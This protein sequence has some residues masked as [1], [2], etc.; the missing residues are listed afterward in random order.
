M[1]RLFPM[2]IVLALVG[3]SP[4]PPSLEEIA[5]ARFQGLPVRDAA[6]SVALRDGVWR[7]EPFAEG[8][9]ARPE[10]RLVEGFRAVGDLTGDGVAEAV[11]LLA[12]SSGG[13][14]VDLVA[15]V[16]GRGPDG[17]VP[18]ASALLGDRVQVCAAHVEDGVLSFYL[19]RAGEGDALCCP[20]ELAVM[21][22]VLRPGA[23]LV[24]TEPCGSRPLTPDVLGGTRWRLREWDAG[25]PA[26]A[27]PAVTLVHEDGRLDGS[28]GCNRWFATLEPGASPGAIAIG[29]IGATR[30][31][32]PEPAAGVER[33]FFEALGGVERFGF[34]AG[35]LAL[36]RRDGQSVRRLLFEEHPEPA[37]S[38]D[39]RRRF[40]SAEAP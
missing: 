27:E 21:E 35:R 1:V 20:G 36:T 30:M 38:R 14:G 2:L 10:V 4:G 11:V 32:C 26:P 33:R 18:L 24:A 34:L 40:C 5:N 13:T 29:V 7:G 37:S 17:P 15:V 9:A 19:V 28:G 39:L 23:G 6:G 8:S 25:D 16:V 31:A 22:L 12:G 3:A